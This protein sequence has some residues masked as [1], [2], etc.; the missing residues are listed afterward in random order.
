MIRIRYWMAAACFACGL[1]MVPGQA[2]AGDGWSYA[3]HTPGYRLMGEA[4]RFYESGWYHSARSRYFAAA[5][6]ADK[7]AQFNVGVMYLHGQGVERDLARGLAWLKLAAERGYP[8]MVTAVEEVELRLED[9]TL[10]QAQEILE[11][12]LLPEYGDAVAIDRTVARM[13]RERR[14]VTGSR[15]GAI[16]NLTVIDQTGQSRSGDDFYAPEKWDFRQIVALETRLFEALAG[17]TVTLGDFE[18]IEDED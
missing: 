11:G 2:P 5:W 12:E 4:A 7:L 14:R 10:R 15:V 18:V 17:T 13:E 9:A 3:E 8:D 1:A 16:G 6:W